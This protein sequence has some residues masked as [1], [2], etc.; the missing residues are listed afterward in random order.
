MRSTIESV[1]KNVKWS[2]NIKSYGYLSN[3]RRDHGE[4]LSDRVVFEYRI[5]YMDLVHE[6]APLMIKPS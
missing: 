6:K 5:Q 2:S 3:K 4:G 1:T